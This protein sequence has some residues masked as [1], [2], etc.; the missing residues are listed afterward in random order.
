MYCVQVDDHI[1]YANGHEKGRVKDS[2]SY[3]WV[4]GDYVGPST[5]R[6]YSDPPI[7]TILEHFNGRVYVVQGKTVWYSEPF[8]YGAFDLVRNHLTLD[9]NVTMFRAVTGGVWVGTER[10]TYFFEGS[11]PKAFKKVWVSGHG[12]IEGT[13]KMVDAS[14]IGAGEMRGRGVIWAATD[15][16]C[17]G[18]ADGQFINLTGPRLSY[19][20]ARYGAGVCMDKRYIALLEP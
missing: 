12:A 19:P 5:T 11:T 15:G 14:K 2:V 6:Q 3:S 1:Y 13:D 17:L 18:S 8:A 16:I 7:G 10:N 20:F 9:T 4:K